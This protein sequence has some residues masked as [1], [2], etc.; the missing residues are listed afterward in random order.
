VGL[1][2]GFVKKIV[3][4]VVNHQLG[5]VERQV[6]EDLVLREGVVGEDQLGEE[7]ALGDLPL[8]VVTRQQKKELTTKR[9]AAFVFVKVVEKRIVDVLEDLRPPKTLRQKS[10]QRRFADTDRTLNRDVPPRE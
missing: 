5:V 10:D 1:R 9:R 3:E 4:P 7:V 8:L 6:G 2:H